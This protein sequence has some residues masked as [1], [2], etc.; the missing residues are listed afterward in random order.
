MNK[1]TSVEGWAFDKIA[2]IALEGTSLKAGGP[3]MA[4]DPP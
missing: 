4:Q 3:Y 1:E 2:F